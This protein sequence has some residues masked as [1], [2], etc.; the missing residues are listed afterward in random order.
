[1]GTNGNITNLE[2]TNNDQGNQGIEQKEGFIKRVQRGWITFKAT[3]AGKVVGTVTKIGKITLMGFGVV[4]VGEMLTA[5]KKE[6]P[7]VVVVTPIQPEDQEP[8]AEEAKE[9]VEA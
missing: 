8:E 4:K 3:P 6:E 1:M 9:A 5:G 2:N 7:K